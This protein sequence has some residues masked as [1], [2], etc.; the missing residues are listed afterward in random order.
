MVQT[1]VRFPEKLYLSLKEEAKR[2]GLTLN[3]YLI[4]ILWERVK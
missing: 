4:S 1:T 2:K 3:A